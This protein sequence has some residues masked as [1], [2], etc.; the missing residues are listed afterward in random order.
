MI[1]TLAK[2]NFSINNIGTLNSFAI[3]TNLSNSNYEGPSFVEKGQPLSAT[4]TIEEG[5]SLSDFSLH[6]AGVLLDAD[7]YSLNGNIITINIE[8]VNGIVVINLVTNTQ[9]EATY[10]NVVWSKGS[11]AAATGQEDNTT[12]NRTRTNAILV[13]EIVNNFTVNNGSSANFIVACYKED[14]TYLGQINTSLDGVIKG[15]GQWIPVG[16]LITTA[17]IAACAP[18]AHTIRLIA[19]SNKNGI[20]LMMN[21]I[22]IAT[23]DGSSSSGGTSGGGATTPTLLNEHF[24][25]G[26]LAKETG[27]E[28]GSTTR[29]RT[30]KTWIIRPSEL[31]GSNLTVKASGFLI[32]GYNADG[33]YLGQYNPALNNFD[34]ETVQTSPIWITDSTLVPVA[35]MLT[36]DRIRIVSEKQTT[37]AFIYLD[38][39][40]LAV[41]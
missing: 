26:S 30:P 24:E 31:N 20:E 35:N 33:A 2:A 10:P 7:A 9:A 34:L 11:L 38:D 15:K 37:A 4:I 6:M 22:I 14:G 23:Y 41:S 18:T 29:G 1:I 27:S 19:D 8:A 13:N 5:Y 32:A 17:I 28:I 36:A 21:G 16:T 40:K 3:L 12:A 25:V 39:E